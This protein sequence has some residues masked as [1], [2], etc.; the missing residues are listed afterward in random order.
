MRAAAFAL[1]L[2]ACGK[3]AAAPRGPTLQVTNRA[4]YQNCTPICGPITAANPLAISIRAT[5]D[6]LNATASVAAGATQ[7]IP[8]TDSVA[9]VYAYSQAAGLIAADSGPV[10]FATSWHWVI[11]DTLFNGGTPQ[12]SP[13]TFA[14]TAACN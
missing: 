10:N 8:V 13:S 4:Y 6:S 12:P 2:L 14:S 7:C 9:Y 5:N 11:R 3:D 1:V